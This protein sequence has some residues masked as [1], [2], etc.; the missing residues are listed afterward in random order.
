MCVIGIYEDKKPE[1]S[2]LVSMEAQ[3]PDGAGLAWVENGRV[4]WKKG[5]DA[6]EMYE[7]CEKV[8]LPI[9]V[10]FRMATAGGNDD[11]LTHPFPIRISKPLALSGLADRLIF[12]NGHFSG[13]EAVLRDFLDRG[14]PGASRSTNMWSDSRLIAYAIGRGVP[15]SVFQGEKLAMLHGSGIID[16]LGFF[17]DT[18]EGVFSNLAWQGF[19]GVYGRKGNHGYRSAAYGAN[20]D[21]DLDEWEDRWTGKYT[22]PSKA[23]PEKV[24]KE[25]RVDRFKYRGGTYVGDDGDL[26]LMQKD[27][28]RVL[29][30]DD[31]N[32][33]EPEDEVIEW[34]DEVK[35]RF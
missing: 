24:S 10:H 15:M 9:I 21:L 31:L 25:T 32:P 23:L 16:T 35:T 11:R 13:W 14:E 5:L 27:G 30:D 26:Y 20:S 7:I 22:A 33:I 4:R 29:V 12:H 17:H 3:N 2:D 6:L 28:T 1:I 8:G 34:P 18:P 19:Y